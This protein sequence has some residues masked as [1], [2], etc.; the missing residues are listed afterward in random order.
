[1]IISLKSYLNDNYFNSVKK[2]HY[3]Y[4]NIDVLTI[5][6]QQPLIF[7]TIYKS[8]QWNWKLRNYNTT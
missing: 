5:N 8:Q 7:N 1:M 3:N 6:T 4:I 2:I